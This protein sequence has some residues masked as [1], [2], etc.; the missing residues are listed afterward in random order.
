MNAI[1][2]LLFAALQTSPQHH[3][4]SYCLYKGDWVSG[5]SRI[6]TYLCPSG[7]KVIT[8]PA[9]GICPSYLTE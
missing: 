4:G 3:Q 9:Y 5:N 1:A 7:Q 6:C 8:I 2:M